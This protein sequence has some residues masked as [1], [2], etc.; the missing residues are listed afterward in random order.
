MR[1]AA[2]S[3]WTHSP[4]FLFNDPAT[5]EIYTLSLHDALPISWMPPSAIVVGPREVPLGTNGCLERVM[6]RWPDGSVYRCCAPTD[7]H[8]RD[9]IVSAAPASLRIRVRS[10]GLADPVVRLQIT[11]LPRRCARVLRMG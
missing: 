4:K 8:A 6:R 3:L 5:T 9:T 10:V 1:A 7:D 11:D 2:Q